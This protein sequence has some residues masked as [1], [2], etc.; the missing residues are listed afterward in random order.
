MTWYATATARTLRISLNCRVGRSPV[1]QEMLGPTQLADALRWIN[2]RG[3]REVLII[4]SGVMMTAIDRNKWQ[5]IFD[6]SGQISRSDLWGGD[7]QNVVVDY[8]DE[9]DVLFAAARAAGWRQIIVFEGDGHRMLITRS[10]GLLGDGINSGEAADAVAFA[11]VMTSNQHVVT[12]LEIP[13]HP[14]YN[15]ASPVTARS[16]SRTPT[17]G[18]C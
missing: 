11:A 18:K 1:D 2:A 8:M 5:A 12:H 10:H 7:R 3:K 6:S 4:I 16:G 15:S 9:R 17:R 13:D 14:D